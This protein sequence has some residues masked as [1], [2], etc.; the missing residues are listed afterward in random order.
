M[1]TLL[2]HVS[3]IYLIPQGGCVNMDNELPS[4]VRDYKSIFVFAVF[5]FREIKQITVFTPQNVNRAHM[6]FG[7]V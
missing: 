5:L 2:R 7:A 3:N 6:S 1:D 4:S